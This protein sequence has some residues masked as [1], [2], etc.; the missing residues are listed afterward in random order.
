MPKVELTN[1]VM[2]QDKTTG[3][4]DQCIK[5]FIYKEN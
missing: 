3:N 5:H 2:V 4:I 1:M